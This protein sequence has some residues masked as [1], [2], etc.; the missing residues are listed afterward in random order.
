MA[1]EAAAAP[2]LPYSVVEGVLEG[3]VAHG[4]G[5]GERIEMEVLVH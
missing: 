2:H 3:Q 4:V 1:G 5:M